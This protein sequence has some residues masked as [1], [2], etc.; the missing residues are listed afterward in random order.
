M[1]TVAGAAVVPGPVDVPA[2]SQAE[3]LTQARRYGEALAIYEQ[4]AARHR[5]DPRPYFRIGAIRQAQ[6]L[7][8]P[9]AEAVLL[10]LARDPGNAAGLALLGRIYAEQGQWAA[11]EAKYQASLTSDPAQTDARLALGRVLVRRGQLGAAQAQMAEA[12][13]QEPNRDEAHY[14]LALLVAPHDAASARTHLAA[15]VDPAWAGRARA[16]EAALVQAE[17]A[18]STGDA[19][20][21]TILGTGYL[22]VNEPALAQPVL[23]HAVR[24]APQYADA[25]AYLGHTYWLLGD[26]RL[27]LSELDTAIAQ[28]SRF[29][30]AHHWRG[31]VLASQ[32]RDDE[33]IAALQQAH[34]LQPDDAVTCADLATVYEAQRDYNVAAEWFQKAVARGL[35]PANGLVVL[36]QARFHVE[37][38]FHWSDVGLAAAQQATELLPGS[39][40]AWELLGWARFL[41]QDYSAARSALEHAIALDVDQPGAHYRLGETWRALGQT[42]AARLEYQMT[43]DLAPE[44]PWAAP[45]RQALSELAMP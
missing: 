7:P 45:A 32:G 35:A 4:L 13:R 25:H 8:I 11:A 17:A 23:Q 39:A 38:A 9:A 34:A 41:G 27:A 24:L 29:A 19:Y 12:L 20:A 26:G 37:H 22:Q 3:S 14:L 28:D 40:E 33:A 6:Q 15:I 43:I 36:R 16:F 1:L 44:G 5:G 10:G 42:D 18:R 30:P 2:L 31:L 21:L